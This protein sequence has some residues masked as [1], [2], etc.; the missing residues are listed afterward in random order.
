MKPEILKKLFAGDPLSRRE[1]HSTLAEVMS[2]KSSPERIAAFLTAL[3]VR[4][5][6]Y[7]E[8]AG[9][10]GAMRSAS[11]RIKTPEGVV[12][13]TCGTGGDGANTINISTAAA[14]VASAGGAIVAKHGNRSVSSKCGSADVLEALGIP[15]DLDVAGVEHCL[16]ETG[17]G[18]LFAPLLHPAMKHVMPVRRALGQR[19]VFNLLGPLTNPAGARRQVLGVFSPDYG[20]V[21]AEALRELGSHHVL[22][23]CGD[24][25][26]GGVLDEISTC[27]TTQVWELTDGSIDQ[28]TIEPKDLGLARSDV[29]AL[30][31]G[32]ATQNAAALESVFAG[33][34]GPRGDAVAANGGAALYVAGLA[35]SLREGAEQA[36]LL[37][38]E[39]AVADRLE[40]LRRAATA[41]RP[42]G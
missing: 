33:E 20:Q 31:G 12:V 42:V 4:G 38:R 5:E 13:D 23:V 25:G 16:S 19:T 26:Q 32:D 34:P 2:G 11:V 36:K 6:T 24:D 30:R 1:A 10:A 15:V 41:C 21:V 8:I 28:S 37:L 14:F 9:M 40:G 27:G 3:R 7:E 35:E 17:I 39:G 29:R 22:V 18:F